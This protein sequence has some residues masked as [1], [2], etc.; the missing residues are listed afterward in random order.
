MNIGILTY[1]WVSNFGANLQAL[2]T[3]RNILS[4][5]HKP[6]FINWIPSDLEQYY[7]KVVPKVQNEMHREFAEKNFVCT[8]IC[9]TSK[10]VAAVIKSY[11][12]EKV[13]IGSDAVFTYIPK[14]KRWHLSRKTL[15][16]Y[17][18]PCA[19]SDFPNPYWA[20]F[21]SEVP[22]NVKVYALSASAQNTPYK[23]I[24]YKYPFDEALSK[25]SFISVRDIW[26]KRMVEYLTNSN[27]SPEIT[28]D[29]VFGFEQNVKP[30]IT[31]A[32]IVRKFSLSNKYVIVSITD[33]RISPDWINQLSSLFVK[34]GIQ[35]IS[36][37]QTNK[38]LVSK[39]NRHITF[40]LDPLYWYSL[41]KYSEGYIGELMHPILV[42]LHNSVPIF[43]F[44]LYG[45]SK[46]GKLDVESS[47]TYQILNQ[48]ELLSNYYNHLYNNAIPCP[49]EV[50]DKI[51]NFDR[52]KCFNNSKQM[53]ERYDNLMNHLLES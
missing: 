7:L 15:I 3:F 1:H 16:G 19:D 44:D 12:I 45:F 50:L 24:F 27:I 23:S 41:I 22:A 52:N 5:G 47:K 11:N 36:L 20:D 53:Y 2:S 9:R 6:I 48:F 39:L 4:A 17:N 30:Q 26:T 25:F 28:P 8:S 21:M 37:D 34:E 43:A 35:L 32:D 38:T 14:L 10:E 51:L 49:S 46:N 40:P 29:P 33:K 31:K 18:K 13:L 42:S